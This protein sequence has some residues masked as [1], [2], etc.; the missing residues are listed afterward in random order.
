MLNVCPMLVATLL[1]TVGLVVVAAA[2]Q[3]RGLRLGGTI[4]VPVLAIYTL[5]AFVMLPIFLASTVVAYAV[6]ALAKRYTLVYGRD[7]LVV[8]VVSGMLI[9]VGVLLFVESLGLGVDASEAAFVGS[10]L[11]GLAAFNYHQLKPQY[12]TEDLLFATGLLGGLLGAGYLL[13]SEPVF[14]LVGT[15]FPAFLFSATADIAQLKGVTVE[16]AVPVFVRREV[17]VGLLAIGMVAA[18]TLRRR[19]GIRLGVISLTLL[20]IY[21]AISAWLVVLF[22]VALFAAATALTLFHQSTLLYGRVL[23]AVATICALLVSLPLALTVPIVRGI[24]AFFVAI[25]AG[26]TAYAIHATPPADRDLRVPLSLLV[27]CP[28]LLVATALIGSSPRGLITGVTVYSVGFLAC[29]CLVSAV[30][31]HRTAVPLPSPE[32]VERAGFVDGTG[33]QP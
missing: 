9:P 14:E 27:F 19:Y 26:V 32:A 15:A 11:P 31:V 1:A 20:A 7:E 6:L 22:V 24:S 4:V 17:Q 16:T 25:L 21:A 5:K 2:T 3:Y 18:E 13:V 10:I 30:Y 23:V 29:V 28:A 12:R 33:G 8:A